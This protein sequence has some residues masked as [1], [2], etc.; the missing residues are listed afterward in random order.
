MKSR[1]TSGVAAIAVAAA[2]ASGATR[3]VEA[4]LAT[5]SQNAATLSTPPAAVTSA[6]NAGLSSA[7]PCS[8]LLPAAYAVQR[9]T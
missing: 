2:V 3:G 1:L 6:A 8:L 7:S 9:P 5:V 4:R